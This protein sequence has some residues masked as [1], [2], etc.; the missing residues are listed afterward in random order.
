MER[1]AIEKDLQLNIV[2][3]I[4]LNSQEVAKKSNEILPSKSA[5]KWMPQSLSGRAEISGYL[6]WQTMRKRIEDKL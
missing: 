4:A 2:F 5:V 6:Q 1:I 3:F